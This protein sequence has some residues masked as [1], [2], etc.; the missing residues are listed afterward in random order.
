MIKIVG[1]DLSMNGSGLVKLTLDNNYDVIK[2]ECEAFCSVK[3]HSSDIVH[4]FKK[5]DYDNRQQINLWMRNKIMA[6]VSDADYA[7]IEDYAFGAKGAVFDIGE[8]VGFIKMNLF[9][10]GIPF[11]LYDPNSIKKYGTGKGN[12]DKI[13]MYDKY[14]DF[15]GMKMDIKAMPIP[16]KGSGVSPTSDVVD[17]F[18]IAKLLQ[19]EIQL[20]KGVITLQSLSEDDI[21]IFNRV[22]KSLPTNILSRDFIK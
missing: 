7:A 3:K 14:M 5:K 18:W 16:N 17:A 6:F 20:R 22:T 4:L 2:T 21:S 19:L 12:A 1:L 15:K 9:E 11:R 8:F 13:T 10:K